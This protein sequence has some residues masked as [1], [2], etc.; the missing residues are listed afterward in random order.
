[1]SLSIKFYN[2]WGVDNNIHTEVIIPYKVPIALVGYLD[3][4][5]QSGRFP[6]MFIC[7]VLQSATRV[8]Y[9]KD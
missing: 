4:P 2:L 1:M 3:L 9:D 5:L 6:V 7:F 8:R